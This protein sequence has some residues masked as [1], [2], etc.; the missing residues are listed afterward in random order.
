MIQNN[1]QALI[2]PHRLEIQPGKDS[3]FKATVVAEPL[4][5]GFGQTIG[6]AL[7]RILLSS[8]QGAAVTSIQ[9]DGVLHEFTSIPGVLEDVTEVILN[10]KTLAL[11]LHEAGPRRMKLVAQGPGPVKASQIE[12]GPEIDILDPDLVICNLDKGA[13]LSM[14]MVVES[15]RGYVSS[16]QNRKPDTPIGLIPIDALFSPVQK[17]SYKVENTRVGQMTNY[18]KL[19]LQVETNGAITPEDAVAL[20]A[21]VLQ[22]QLQQFI[23]FEDPKEEIKEPELG[24]ETDLLRNLLRRVEELELS[25]RSANCLKNENIVYIGDLVQRTE[26]DLLKTPNFGRKSLAEIRAVLEEHSLHLGMEIPDWPPENIDE[27]AKKL[28]NPY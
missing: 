21:R 22:D 8:L 4:E 27:L 28:E 13:K 18:D 3:A 12:A 6:N 14:E 24:I 2:K 15:G 9:V 25:V 7:R 19:V 20:S 1:W 5:K 11:R 26:Q 10:I 17:V 23:N 16:N